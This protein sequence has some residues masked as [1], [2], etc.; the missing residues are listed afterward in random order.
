MRGPR[1]AKTA[2]IASAGSPPL[3]V[4]PATTPPLDKA[5][6]PARADPSSCKL[7][8]PA[9]FRTW[10]PSPRALQQSS[11]PSLPARQENPYSRTWLPSPHGFAGGEGPGV[12]GP[13]PAK[14]ASI[15]SAGSPPLGVPPRDESIADRS[16][17]TRRSI[18]GSGAKPGSRISARA[19]PRGGKIPYSKTCLPSPLFELAHHIES[20]MGSRA[21]DA[22]TAHTDVSH[23]RSGR[24]RGEF[25]SQQP[26]GKR[27]W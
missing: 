20:V 18:G 12:R 11:G 24:Q 8:E 7:P 3:R 17:F 1:P 10:L 15:A 4:S 22:L 16:R 27:S 9:Y 14:P 13:S 25:Q 2:P 23:W 26:L 6:P 21:M 5:R 19:F